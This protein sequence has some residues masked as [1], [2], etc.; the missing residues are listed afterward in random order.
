MYHSHSLTQAQIQQANALVVL[1][2][3]RPS[4]RV[5][6][7]PTVFQIYGIPIVSEPC[8]T[9]NREQSGCAHFAPGVTCRSVDRTCPY[10]NEAPRTLWGP[11]VVGPHRQKRR[12]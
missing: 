2:R 10:T 12:H 9:P 8:P 5:T 4:G 3:K 6:A 1:R 7:T 11:T